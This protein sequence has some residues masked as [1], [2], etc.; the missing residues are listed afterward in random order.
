MLPNARG[1]LSDSR[2]KLV[3]TG[4]SFGGPSF[5]YEI[6]NLTGT[7]SNSTPGANFTYGGGNVDGA[8]VSVITLTQS[9]QYL[10]IGVA[11]CGTNAEDNSALADI[12]VDPAGGTSW[13]TLIDDLVVGFT[14]G[15]ANGTGPMPLWY[16][17]PLFVASGSSLGIRAKKNG[18]TAATSGY[19]VMFGFGNPSNQ[20]AW[21][22]G[23]G[24]ESLGIADAA[25]SKATSITPGN[26]GAWSSYATIGTSTRQYRAIQLGLNGSDSAASNSGYHYQIGIGGTQIAGTPTFYGSIATSET[27]AR[28]QFYGPTYCNI[29]SG[30]A[31]QLRATCSGAAE[32]QNV[33]IYGVY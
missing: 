3:G 16:H 28:T 31:I 24:V 5:Q 18:A 13:T 1:K 7:P 19:C 9:I 25:N 27:L 23:T 12:L 4:T 22:Y 20:R 8:A 29:P 32:A 26:T 10:V 30:S 6:S 2:G 33:A 21:D 15:L 14:G 11:G 17:F